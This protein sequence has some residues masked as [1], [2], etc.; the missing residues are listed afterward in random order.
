MDNVMNINKK[1]KLISTMK[2]VIKFIH[3]SILQQDKILS[4]DFFALG[5]YTEPKITN[6]PKQNGT[7][8]KMVVLL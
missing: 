2:A 8:C 3:W 4:S 1:Q 7:E 6:P 5:V